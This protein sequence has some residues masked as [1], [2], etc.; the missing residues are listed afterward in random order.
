MPTK[1]AQEHEQIRWSVA[2][3]ISF[4]N[5]QLVEQRE[6]IPLHFRSPPE[7]LP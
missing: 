5:T 7:H 1:F 3:C 6:Q 2:L 4:L